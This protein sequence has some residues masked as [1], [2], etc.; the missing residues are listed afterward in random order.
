MSLRYL[1]NLLSLTDR[2]AVRIAA[3]L[4]ICTTMW[5]MTPR[6][7]PAMQAT[8][9]LTGIVAS[10]ETG[11]P[12]PNAQVRLDEGGSI[13]FTD[14]TGM[15]RLILTPGEQSVSF[16]MVGY[17]P[18]RF[19]LD[20]PATSAEIDIGLVDLEPAQPRRARLTGIVTDRA[21]ERPLPNAILTLNG[22]VIGLTDDEG[23]FAFEVVGAVTGFNQMSVKR[24]GYAALTHDF[25]L[26]DDANSVDLS[27]DIEQLPYRLEEIVVSAERTIYVRGALADF[28]RRRKMGFG[29]FLTEQEIEDAHAHQTTDLLRRF[30]GVRILYSSNGFDRFVSFGRAGSLCSGAL[31]YLDG[32]PVPQDFGIDQIAYPDMLAGIEV[33][34]GPAQIPVQY[35]MSGSACGVVLLWTK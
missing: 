14:S 20:I 9:V 34:S 11:A 27:L 10:A 8:S 33:Y 25:W 18:R 3:A 1:P 13:T 26:A 24:I 19:R 12:V 28:Y 6:R 5:L 31:V 30:P 17:V 2:L 16:W 22:G 7:L 35:N 29:R 21:S 15:F 23:R 32:A 4:C